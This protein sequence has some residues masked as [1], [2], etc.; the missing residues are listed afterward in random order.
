MLITVN[1]REEGG[2]LTVNE[3]VYR[4]Y[5]SAEVTLFWVSSLDEKKNKLIFS[6]TEL[7]PKDQLASEPLG[8]GNTSDLSKTVCKDYKTKVHCRR[9]FCTIGEAIEC[10]DQFDWSSLGGPSGLQ[11]G[12]TLKRQ[13][14]Q[15]VSISLSQCH[16]PLGTKQQNLSMVLPD[17]PTSFRSYG[18]I[19][20]EMETELM[21]SASERNA[22]QKFVV[23][24]CGADLGL[25]REFWGASILCMQNPI[26]WGCESFGVDEHKVLHL[27][28]L[29]RSGESVAGMRYMVQTAHPFGIS[30]AVM[31]EV[32]SEVISFP[33]P[34]PD[35]DPQ[36][37]L[38]DQAGNLLEIRPLSFW[39]PI[40]HATSQRRPLPNG[41]TTAVW[42]RSYYESRKKRKPLL[43]QQEEARMYK[44]LED[45]RQFFFFRAGEGQRVRNIVGEI[46]STA[47]LDITLCDMYMD[48]QG[49]DNCVKGWIRCDTLTIFASKHWLLQNNEVHKTDLIARI[50][51]LIDQQTVRSAFLYG[52]SGGSHNNGRMHDRFFIA[53]ETV[54]CLGSSF[55][56]IG[57]RDTVL[58]KPPNPQV[59]IDRTTEWKNECVTLI[60][61]RQV[62]DDG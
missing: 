26:I 52:V 8:G 15:G 32:T 31:H 29:P 12:Q 37:Y 41:K 17:R 21:F 22:I 14:A 48:A 35:A 61:E 3:E 58:F 28:L 13:P 25:Y 11:R 53:D 59:F 34:N 23:R 57:D 51:E 27:L 6:V 42:P 18:F 46:L 50:S 49:F 43:Q 62:D 39:G 45:Q 36:L 56:G 60:F 1:Y 10:F 54:Y 55:H 30:D 4:N 33:I 16:T 5:L 24:Y 20:D 19:E 44:M 7:I 47:G 9:F 38:W 2:V 40:G